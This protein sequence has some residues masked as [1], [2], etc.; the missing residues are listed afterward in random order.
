[1]ALCG[2][3]RFPLMQP[4]LYG[5]RPIFTIKWRAVARRK[6]VATAMLNREDLSL[7][8]TLF[9]EIVAPI[10]ERRSG[11]WFGLLPAGADGYD[12]HY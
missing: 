6:N 11:Q 7:A 2:A 12:Y 1:M 4:S 10:G 5:D 9:S 8:S 3:G